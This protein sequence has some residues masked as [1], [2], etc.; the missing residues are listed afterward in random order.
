V[1]SNT[2][3]TLTYLQ[4]LGLD[5]NTGASGVIYLNDLERVT[6]LRQNSNGSR[7]IRRDCPVFS[8]FKI[9]FLY[10]E[11]G[12]VVAYK[13]CGYKDSNDLLTEAA[14]NILKYKQKIESLQAL[15]E[16]ATYQAEVLLR[17]EYFKYN[18][19]DIFE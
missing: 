7:I 16:N 1:N 11:E 15:I 5:L 10:S 3:K 17:S 18:V 8:K 13:F 2:R 12:E 4:C 19:Q 14:S 6:G 9:D